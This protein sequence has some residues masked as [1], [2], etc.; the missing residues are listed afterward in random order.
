ME[1]PVEEAAM[2]VAKKGMKKGLKIALYVLGGLVAL[3]AVVLITL[4]L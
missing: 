2:P 4:P 1:K 3:I